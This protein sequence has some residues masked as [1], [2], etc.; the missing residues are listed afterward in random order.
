MNVFKSIRDWWNKDKEL[1]EQV[2]RE[3]I[4][5]Y[6]DWEDNLMLLPVGE[7]RRRAAALLAN[8][9]RFRCE[10]ALLTHEDRRKLAPLA[11]LLREFLERYSMVEAVED[12]QYVSREL[13]G[14]DGPFIELGYDQGFTRFLVKPG[15]EAIYTA[16]E[17]TEG[18]EPDRLCDSIYH[19][20]LYVDRMNE[21]DRPTT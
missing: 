12:S 1:Y 14:T 10:E 20:L 11:P 19:C 6:D 3:V 13:K 21:M 4:Q 9:D 2:E 17:A 18:P 15:D 8:P 7:A 5:A 16:G